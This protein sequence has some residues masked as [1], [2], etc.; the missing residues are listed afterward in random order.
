M[1]CRAACWCCFFFFQAEDGIRDKLVT[2][3]QTCA[4]PIWPA[5][6]W[7]AVAALYPCRVGADAGAERP[8]WD[9]RCRA[10]ARRLWA[11]GDRGMV[12]YGTPDSLHSYLGADLGD[13]ARLAGGR[14]AADRVLGTML[15]WRT[16]SGGWPELFSRSQ[17]DYGRNLP[18]HATSAA[19]FLTL[20]RNALVC[21]EGTSLM[22]TLGAREAW[23]RGAKLSGAPTR[24]GVLDV[25]FVRGGGWRHAPAR[26]GRG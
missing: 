23:W 4:L 5:R 6:D 2:G 19:A 14:D 18:P 3:V 21:D 17:R 12:S 24:W 9:R 1:H 26:R 16:A 7:G 25:T 20:V 15:D 10:L 13:W 22:L 8:D 11:R